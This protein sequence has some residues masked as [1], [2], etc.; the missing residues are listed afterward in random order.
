MGYK[1]EFSVSFLATY[2]LC[3]FMGVCICILQN[4]TEVVG[5]HFLALDTGICLILDNS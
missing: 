3:V 5:L 2:H 4:C 1:V